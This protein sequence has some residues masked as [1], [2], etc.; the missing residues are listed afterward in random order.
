M[1]SRLSGKVV[2][3][4]DG[5]CEVD[6]HGLTYSVRVGDRKWPAPGT[7]IVVFTHLHQRDEGPSLFGFLNAEEKKAFLILLSV[8]GVGP[9]L[10]QS[11]VVALGPAGLAQ[12]IA[13]RNLSLLTKVPGLGRKRAESLVQ[14]LKDRIGD[15]GGKDASSS[16]VQVQDLPGDEVAEGLRALGYSDEEVLRAM[17]QTG[18]GSTDARLREAITWL[19]AHR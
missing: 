17:E 6:V 9:K 8:H 5:L 10:A 4:S 3:F 7:D 16:T 18:K 14:E 2:A 1:I 12:A 19:G 15:I 13:D 11:A